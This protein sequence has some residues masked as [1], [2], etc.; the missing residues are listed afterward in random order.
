MT[1]K[2]VAAL[3]VGS[4]LAVTSLAQQS[5]AEFMPAAAPLQISPGT[6][7]DGRIR[8]PYGAANASCYQ[9]FVMTATGGVGLYHWTWKA[10]PGSSLPAGLQL[11][12]CADGREI[13][14]GFPTV[15]GSYSVVVTVW[16]NAAPQGFANATYTITILARLALAQ[17]PVATTIQGAPSIQVP[18]PAWSVAAQPQ[19]SPSAVP[20]HFTLPP[21]LTLHGLAYSPQ[22]QPY[23]FETGLHI[24][25]S[26]PVPS[27]A[28]GQ[29]FGSR[30][31]TQPTSGFFLSA[32][33]GVPP[34]TWSWAAA[35]GSTLPDGVALTGCVSSQ[36]SVPNQILTPPPDY[37]ATATIFGSPR[38][39]GTFNVVVTVADSSS[40]GFPSQPQ[41]ATA[42][43]TFNVAWPQFFTIVTRGGPPVG[44]VGVQYGTQVD[45]CPQ[46]FLVSAD[47]S[48]TSPY[49]WFFR[50]FQGTH[51]VENGLSMAP[52]NDPD[53]QVISG[54]PQVPGTYTATVILTDSA[55][56][57]HTVSKDYTITV[58][59]K[60]L[61]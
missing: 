29:F 15:A 56:P 59:T 22:P 5:V 16:D 12:A 55:H 38:T 7:P 9:G 6:P 2:F 30:C 42:N 36:F 26:G 61:P 47:G 34:Y 33:G 58:S 32:S 28:V 13:I 1:R 54:V 18:P 27:S 23:R 57:Q 10:A 44:Y 3:A 8:V 4:F 51:L 17:A 52:C 46:G 31:T 24:I 20:G 41:R 48:G 11:A 14:G 43:L 35:P 50:L 25:A 19:A 60:L 49:H 39:G 37:S 21:T 40:S 53:T 45:G